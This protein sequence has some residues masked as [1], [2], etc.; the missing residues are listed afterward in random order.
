MLGL[1]S[2]T[3]RDEAE[4]NSPFDDNKAYFDDES[5]LTVDELAQTIAAGIK[6]TK[7][8]D[9]YFCCSRRSC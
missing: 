8:A 7:I 5:E 9:H 3:S 4:D 2:S 1:D 6:G